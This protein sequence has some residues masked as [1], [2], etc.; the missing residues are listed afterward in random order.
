MIDELKAIF[1]S[2]RSDVVNKKQLGPQ[3]AEIKAKDANA[4]VAPI[5]KCPFSGKTASQGE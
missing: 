5:S 3:G 2:V 1:Y 4:D